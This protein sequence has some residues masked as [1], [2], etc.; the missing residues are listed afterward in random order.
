MHQHVAERF[1]CRWINGHSLIVSIGKVVLLYK[2]CE[3]IWVF[4]NNN[5][6]IAF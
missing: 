5:T 4:L 6:A 3:F 2:N 1:K